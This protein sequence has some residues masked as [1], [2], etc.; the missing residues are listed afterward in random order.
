MA[1]DGGRTGAPSCGHLAAPAGSP[2]PRPQSRGCGEC[3]ASG[4][5]WVHLRKCL[6]CGHVGCCDSSR[7]RHAWAHADTT[8]HPVARSLERGD[9]WAWCYQDDLFLVPAVD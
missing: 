5:S 1:P 7:G 9:H 2:E 3:L 4:G 6:E 8:G